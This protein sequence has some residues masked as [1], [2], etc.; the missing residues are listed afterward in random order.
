MELRQL[1]HDRLELA[2][3]SRTGPTAL[4][5]FWL[6][7]LIGIV[8]VIMIGTRSWSFAP[9]VLGAVFLLTF[10]RRRWGSSAVFDRE[11]GIVMLFRMV[12]KRR[13]LQESLPLES[14]DKVI[15]EAQSHRGDPMG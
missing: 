14:I 3:S 10:S 9:I 1:E 11:K 2:D 4:P 12:D 5:R 7:V 6:P 13:E 15:V 8:V